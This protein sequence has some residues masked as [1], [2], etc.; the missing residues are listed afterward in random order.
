M[1]SNSKTGAREGRGLLQGM[2]FCGICGRRM[3]ISYTSKGDPVYSC[4]TVLQRQA[5]QHINGRHVDRV[6]AQ[7]L[8]DTLSRQELQ[9]A[10]KAE[11]MHY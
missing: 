1:A 7:A 6:V 2:V 4:R 8:L 5:C 10:A 9:L 11:E 3:G